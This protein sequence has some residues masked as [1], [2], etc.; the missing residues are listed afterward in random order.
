MENE[1]KTGDAPKI[2][3]A[4][5]IGSKNAQKMRQIVIETDGNDIHLVKAEVSGRIELIGIFQN[6]IG[7]INNLK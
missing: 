7:Y 3:G 1:E 4:N 5:N 6:L 2:E